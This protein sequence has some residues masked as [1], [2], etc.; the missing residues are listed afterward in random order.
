MHPT[1]TVDTG[2]PQHRPRLKWVAFWLVIVFVGL[3]IMNIDSPPDIWFAGF[4]VS[5]VALFQAGWELRP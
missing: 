5:L 3:G 4:L 2:S 1:I